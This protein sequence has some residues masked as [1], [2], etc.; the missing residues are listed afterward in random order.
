MKILDI[1]RKDKTW[2]AVAAIAS[3]VAAFAAWQAI[4]QTN[5]TFESRRPYLKTYDG[6]MQRIDET[7]NFSFKIGLE[8]IGMNPARDPE[9]RLVVINKTLNEDL[10]GV[11]YRFADDVPPSG[12]LSFARKDINP[13][14]IKEDNYYT[15][16]FTSSQTAIITT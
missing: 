8:D 15:P 12:N 1:F 10:F 6:T 13:S 5:Y 11:F 7:N 16:I 2:T 4:I 9:M 14:R 3:A